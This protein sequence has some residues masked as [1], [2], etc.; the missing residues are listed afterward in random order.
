MGWMNDTLAYMGEEPVH[1]KYHHH[2]MTFGMV[3]AFTENFILPLSHDE[4]VH[5]KGSLIGRMPGDEWQRFANLRAYFAYM[6]AH[7]GK[8]LLFMGGEF[9]Q[10]SEWDHQ[11]SL[12]WHLLEHKPHSGMQA[13]IRQLNHCY[14]DL[15]ALFEVDFEAQGFEWIDCD[16]AQHSIY[17]WL[18]RDR[19]GQFMICLC[20]FTPVVRTN[21]RLGVPMAGSYR[22]ILNTDSEQFGGSGT[23]SM[24]QVQTQQH[25]AHGRAVSLELCLPPL[26]TLW[27]QPGTIDE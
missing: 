11:R 20:N 22:V 19:N 24:G 21:Y 14:R 23:G 16:D 18:R 27:L 2:K 12:D 4:V 1:R 6:Y 15:P 25:S 3:Y 26:A 9:A 10:W 5:G 13:L 7:P 17:A 8:K